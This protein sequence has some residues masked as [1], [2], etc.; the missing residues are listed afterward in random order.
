MNIGI[1]FILLAT[2]F[3][4]HAADSMDISSL[5]I[6]DGLRKFCL[7]LQE[8]RFGHKRSTK[9][10]GLVPIESAEILQ[11][12]V[13]LTPS[14]FHPNFLGIPVAPHHPRWGQW[15][16]GSLAIRPWNYYRSIPTCMKIIRQRHR[17]T[18]GRTDN[19]QSHNRALHSSIAW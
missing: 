1:Y 16:Q 15:E 12:F 5:K 2:R 13:L 19:M 14:L 17:Q 9:V 11:V 3:I 8:W 6:Y 4:H 18:D 10:I 7:F